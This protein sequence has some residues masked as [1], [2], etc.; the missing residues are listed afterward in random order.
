M[1]RT[2][3]LRTRLRS[4]TNRLK[5]SYTAELD[6]SNDIDPWKTFAWLVFGAAVI[7]LLD[8]LAQ[9]F[10]VG[11][12]GLFASAVGAPR[13]P[14]KATVPAAIIIGAGCGSP[15]PPPP[16]PGPSTGQ[17]GSDGDP[18]PGPGGGPPPEPSGG[19]PPPGPDP[20]L[21]LRPE[22]KLAK[23][24]IEAREAAERINEA[25]AQDRAKER[26]RQEELWRDQF[27]HAKK[28]NPDPVDEGVKQVITG[29]LGGVATGAPVAEDAGK[30]LHIAER[31][32]DEALDMARAPN[33][34]RSGDAL[35]ET[36]EK[37]YAK[38]QEGDK[39]DTDRPR[40]RGRGLNWIWQKLKGRRY[41]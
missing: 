18:A 10:V 5:S 39:V 37:G 9:L 40:G 14:G 30:G 13:N 38:P 35:V 3:A 17:G 27:E 24:L 31:R 1:R 4:L 21:P 23:D 22:D 15:V 8:S 28:T 2:L 19:G 7:G 33:K 26:A 25:E 32:R 16:A 36:D 34:P 29:P 11:P 20:N 6:G 12:Q 41:D